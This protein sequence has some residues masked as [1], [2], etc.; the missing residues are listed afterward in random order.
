[1]GVARGRAA[2]GRTGGADCLGPLALMEALGGRL[3]RAEELAAESASRRGDGTDRQVGACGAAA[4]VALASVHVERNEL[5]PARR[6]HKRA[7]D[8]LRT[9]PD[10]LIGVLASLVAARYSLAEGR[11]RAVL[12]IMSPAREGWSP[13]AWIDHRMLLLESWA[14]TAREDLQ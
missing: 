11:G 8:A 5:P 7:E 2:S 10:K 6:W 14:P 13:P 1:A 9:R 3:S 4:E 12:D